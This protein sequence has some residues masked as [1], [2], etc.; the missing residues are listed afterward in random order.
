MH[1]SE[2]DPLPVPGNRLSTLYR[3]RGSCLFSV[4]HRPWDE[5]CHLGVS[6]ELNEVLEVRRL[7]SAK[8]QPRGRDFPGP[9]PRSMDLGQ[10]ATDYT[11]G[12]DSFTRVVGHIV[13]LCGCGNQFIQSVLRFS[14]PVEKVRS[15]FVAG[16][17]RPSYSKP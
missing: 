13:A 10:H 1:D 8:C 16:A 3:E 11:R 9:A 7:V 2:D 12:I 6:M 5:A 4:A 15:G 17:E 14:S